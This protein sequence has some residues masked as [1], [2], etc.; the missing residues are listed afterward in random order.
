MS[1][2]DT[3]DLVEKLLIELEPLK[4]NER[5]VKLTSVSPHIRAAIQKQLAALDSLRPYSHPDD[6]SLPETIGPYRVVS[7][8]GQSGYSCVYLCQTRD[9]TQVAVKIL[10]P[11]RSD[12]YRLG[13]FER[14]I[15][16]IEKL[17]HA[18]ICRF[19]EASSALFDG[20]VTPYFSME[21]V[22]GKHLDEYVFS[23]ELDVQN[24]V[25]LILGVCDAVAFAHA[26][27]IIHRDLK[28]SN[29]LVTGDGQAKV[30]DF[31]IARILEPDLETITKL[32]DARSILGTLSYI[33]PEQTIS[34]HD[35]DTRS[36]IYSLGAITFR[37]LS[38]SLPI[39][40]TGKNLPAA[41]HA[42]HN[43]P[44][45]T[46]SSLRPQLAGDLEQILEKALQKNPNDRYRTVPEFSD[47]LCRFLDGKPVSV[48][49]DNTWYR[50]TK[51][52]KR[53]PLRALLSASILLLFVALSTTALVFSM[54]ANSRMAELAR[55]Q[56]ESDANLRKYQRSQF[57][58]TLSDMAELMP[59][60]PQAVAS[61]LDDP[62][63]CPIPLR[64]FTWNYLRSRAKYTQ[65][66]N[67]TTTSPT[68]I[69]FG[70]GKPARLFVGYASGEI[71]C[72][73]PHNFE[74]IWEHPGNNSPVRALICQADD[75]LLAVGHKNGQI[76]LVHADT[77]NLSRQIDSENTPVRTLGFWPQSH[78]LVSVHASGKVT[79]RARPGLTIVKEYDLGHG[80]ERPVFFSL[81]K[82]TGFSKGPTTNLFR[83]RRFQENTC[84]R[85]TTWPI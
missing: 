67:P 70:H 74:T 76:R 11:T 22:E 16:A 12:V 62:E 32:H 29:I 72:L 28:P 56:E 58:L 42:I 20:T 23:K 80:I 15:R 4:A 53:N 83:T 85:Q 2:P 25:S 84:Q 30:L 37:L 6:L 60:D 59:F 13:R 45:K 21:H 9:N 40:L 65:L 27:G 71:R 64:E 81:S 73:N 63:I 79:V 38:R 17:D 75:A 48:R 55:K 26:K 1:E 66:R 43:A 47:D 82:A 69:T 5:E 54:L 39:E 31:G 78:D 7:Q 14:E 10:I 33:S 52:A 49:P 44:P 46:L 35:V 3:R 68:R 24:T 19:I 51:W 18:G 41:I 57:N 34:S 8:L 50:A 36:D 61:T 77:G